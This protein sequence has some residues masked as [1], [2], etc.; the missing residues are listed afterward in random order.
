MGLN[1]KTHCRVTVK[2]E[3]TSGPFQETTFTAI[4]L[5][6]AHRMHTRRAHNEHNSTFTS[7]DGHICAWIKLQRAPL[8]AHKRIHLPVIHVVTLLVFAALAHSQPTTTRSTTWTARPH[9]VIHASCAVCEHPHTSHFLVFVRTHFNVAHDIGSRWLSASCHPCFMWLPSL[10][11]SPLC[12]LH[13]LS[14][15]PFHFPDL[16]LHLPCGLVRGEVHCAL[17]R[18]RS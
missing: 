7:T 10:F 9:H 12:T 8:S 6:H 1:H 17:P 15:L 16:H 5:N 4:T 11:D 3:T 2:H 14:H 18:M 13:H